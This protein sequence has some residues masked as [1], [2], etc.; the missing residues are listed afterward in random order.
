MRYRLLMNATILA[1]LAI[2]P[3]AMVCAEEGGSDVDRL[4]AR[5]AQQDREA[6]QQQLQQVRECCVVLGTWHAIGPFKHEQYGHAP[7]SLAFPYDVERDVLAAGRRSADLN[8]SYQAQRFPGMVETERRWREHPEWIDGYRHLLLRGPAPARGEAVYLY[9]T[10]SCRKATTLAMRVYAEDYI[11]AWLNGRDLGRADRGSWTASRFPSALCIDLPL[12]QGENRLLIKVASLCGMHGFAFSLE[13]LTPSHE[14]EPGQWDSSICREASA[15]NFS[16]QHQPLT[17][18]QPASVTYP[19]NESL[20][21]CIASIARALEL[22]VEEVSPILAEIQPSRLAELAR[23]A[24]DH[25]D[26]LARLRVF[27]F[28]ITM[29]PMFDPPSSVMAEEMERRFEDSPGGHDYVTALSDLRPAVEAALEQVDQGRPGAAAAGLAAYDRL[30]TMWRSEAAKLSPILFIRRPYVRVDARA[31]YSCEGSTPSA[32]CLFDPATPSEPARVVFEEPGTAIYDMCLGLDANSIYFSAKR[33][34]AEGGWHIYRVGLDGSGLTQITHGPCNDISPCALPGGQLAFVSTRDQNWV[35][36]APRKA[37]HLFLAAADGSELRKASAN[38]DSDHTPPLLEDGRILFT[39][40]D[41][42]VEKN[43]FA[44]HALWTVNS[45]GTGMQLFAGNTIEDP[46]G[47]W[48][49]RQ[50]SGRPVAVCVF[51][52]HH[53]H[54]SGMIGLVWNQRGTEAPRGEGFRFITNEIPSYADTTFAFGYEDPYPLNERLFLM[55]Y[56]GDGNRKARLY[57]L[58]DRGNRRCLYEAA[59][60]LGCYHPLPLDPAPHPV[61]RV[62]RTT[63]HTWSYR[64]PFQRNLQPDDSVTATLFLA[65]VHR[66]LSPHVKRGEARYLQILEQVPKTV[67]HAQDAWGT[68]PLT[69]RGTVHVRRLIGTV[70]LEQD[71]SACFLVPALRSLSFNVLDAQGKLLM[72]MGADA[73]FMPGEQRGCVGCH[74]VNEGGYPAPFSV[75]PSVSKTRLAIPDRPDWG[76]AGLIDYQRVVQPIWDQYCVSCHSGAL[77]DGGVDM[78]GDRTRYFCASYDNLVERELVDY[79]N[80]FALEHDETPIKAIGSFVSRIAGY[81]ETAEHSGKQMPDQQRRT[82][83]TWIDANIPYYSTYRFTR[84][85][86]RGSRDAWSLSDTLYRA[87]D[88]RCMDCHRRELFNP[89]LYGGPAVVSSKLWTNRGITAHGFPQRWPETAHIGP[90]LRINLTNPANSLL[91]R[92]P[93][94]KAEGGFGYCCQ[95]DG[96]PVFA[97]QEDPDY[98]CMLGVI[99]NAKRELYLNPRVD[100][101][102]E[103]VASVLPTLKSEVE[104]A[105]YLPHSVLSEGLRQL[106]ALPAGAENLSLRARGA[107][108]SRH[109]LQ[110]IPPGRCEQGP[111]DGDP[112]TLWDEIDGKPEYA[113]CAT[114]KE[115]TRISVLSIVGWKHHDF[116]PRGF[117]ILCDGKPVGRIAD[118]QYQ[119]NRLS[120]AFDPVECLTVELRIDEYYGGSPA[121]RELEFYDL[122]GDGK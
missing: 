70:P 50:V 108:K 109:P 100:M 14:L 95:E 115:R 89:S 58:D 34:Q 80:V 1:V 7:D 43:V 29:T 91:L 102:A 61:A 106:K 48:K 60:S 64:D 99:E 120:L 110:G 74:E 90:E 18:E 35:T 51:G 46:A 122:S 12:E 92:A 54:Q 55:T 10:I 2:N 72:R 119:A 57:L 117:E 47:F 3:T 73:S 26:A 31:P 105:K 37:A 88:R 63:P 85:K 67:A 36:C 59:G 25:A 6:R 15:S 62:A 56:G 4:I 82:I 17:C 24:T 101:S 118:A 13:G 19:Q 112:K 49:G 66:G 28:E 9:R 98:Q 93:L 45:D 96:T 40:W 32:I 76:T 39:R 22:R 30:E 94:A 68:S 33:P 44:R 121:I 5:K 116:A 52:P 23:E 16:R 79:H 8:K 78:T 20:T 84:P 42:G 107:S 103:H 114:F 77:P 53:T 83:Y 97:D 75:V 69:G 111:L 87:F 104:L 41:Y 81:I 11:A 21:D 65:D 71:G 86:T 38:I 27:R 113:Y